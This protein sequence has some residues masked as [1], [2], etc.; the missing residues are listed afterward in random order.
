MNELI[1]NIENWF[2]KR[3]LLAEQNLTAQLNKL[4]SE[5]DELEE[6]MDQQDMDGF[7]DAVGD[8]FVV[9]AGMAKIKGC[10]I[11]ECVRG[12]FNEIKDRQGVTVDGTFIKRADLEKLPNSLQKALIQR[13]TFNNL[14]STF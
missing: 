10:S 3:D 13:A 1:K 9:L 2:A 12:A 8:I 11:E 4:R 7:K 5:V 14:D 6:A